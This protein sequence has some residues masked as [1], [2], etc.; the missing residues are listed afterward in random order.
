MCDKQ[1]KEDCREKFNNHKKTYKDFN[2]S[3]KYAGKRVFDKENI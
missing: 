1:F 3:S 2:G